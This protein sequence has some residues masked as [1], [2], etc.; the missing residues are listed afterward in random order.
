MYATES[1]WRG[2][3]KGGVVA[4][5]SPPVRPCPYLLMP[6]YMYIDVMMIPNKLRLPV[7]CRDWTLIVIGHHALA[8]V[9]AHDIPFNAYIAM[10]KV[11]VTIL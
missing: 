9:V 6:Y 1:Q 4:F 10:C 5:P 8:Y 3:G 7:L 11:S 2:L